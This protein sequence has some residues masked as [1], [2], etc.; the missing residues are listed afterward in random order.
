MIC[1]NAKSKIIPEPYGCSLVIG[2]WNYP[3]STAIGP[4]CEA[5]AAGNCVVLKPSEIAPNLSNVLKNIIEK[6]L[7][8]EC[9]A[10][11][12]GGA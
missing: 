10:V 8:T 9:Y 4:F 1:G 5:L 2:S 6:Y 12:E 3:L 7:D 11:I